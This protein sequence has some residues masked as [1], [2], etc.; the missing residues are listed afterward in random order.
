MRPEV[1]S[2][3][4]F[5]HDL[6]HDGQPYTGPDKFIMRSDVLFRTKADEGAGG[7]GGEGGGES[8]A[9]HIS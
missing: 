3:V 8:K 5:P 1:G 4:I 6:A 2:V 7:E 9:C